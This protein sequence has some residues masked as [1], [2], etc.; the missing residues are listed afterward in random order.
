MITLCIILRLKLKKIPSK[1][2]HIFELLLDGALGLVDQVTNDR[3][4]S[5]KIF[6]LVLSLFLFHSYK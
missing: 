1:I 4:I 2:Q 6:P 3:R 5:L